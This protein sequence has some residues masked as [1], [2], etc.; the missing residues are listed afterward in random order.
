VIVHHGEVTGANVHDVTVVPELLIGEETEVFGES[1]YLSADKREGT[2]T[3]NRIG[4]TIRYKVNRRPSQG[5][6]SAVRSKSQ[7]RHRERE[8]SAIRAKVEHVIGL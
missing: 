8:K 2:I 5:K 3:R 6:N 4:K 7:I 1:G